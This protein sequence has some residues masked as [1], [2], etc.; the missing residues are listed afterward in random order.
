MYR[1][2]VII[3]ILPI[4]TKDIQNNLRMRQII[5]VELNY[6]QYNKSQIASYQQDI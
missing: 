5:P 3:N 1:Y 6:F 2:L 4:A